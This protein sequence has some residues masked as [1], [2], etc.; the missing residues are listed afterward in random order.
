MWNK[1]A[2]GWASLGLV[3]AFP[4]GKGNPGAHP[5][6]KSGTERHELATLLATLF[7][8][9]PKGGQKGGHIA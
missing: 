3:R 9:T 8:V 1:G 2:A 5:S 6:T 4:I 7:G